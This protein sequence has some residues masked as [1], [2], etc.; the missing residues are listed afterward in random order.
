MTRMTRALIVVTVI[1]MTISVSAFRTG[2]RAEHGRSTAKAC[3]VTVTQIGLTPSVTHAHS[4]GNDASWNIHNN[5]AS[6]ITFTS[7]QNAS[8]G[9]INNVSIQSGTSVGPGANADAD[10]LFDVNNVGDTGTVN[11]AFSAA[12][13]GIAFPG[14][15]IVVKH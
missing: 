6:T 8:T 15:H 1:A 9:A 14:Y 11:L 2:L 3:N 7:R 5:S 4:T 13:G 10:A 12:C